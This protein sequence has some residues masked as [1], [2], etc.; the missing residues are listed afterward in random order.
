[1]NI[2]ELMI[3]NYVKCVGC[4]DNI[5]QVISLFD[6]DLVTIQNSDDT[7]DCMLDRVKPIPITIEWLMKNGFEKRYKDILDYYYYTKEIKDCFISITIRAIS[8][9]HSI[10][11]IYNNYLSS[12]SYADIQYIHQLQNLLNILYIKE[13]FIV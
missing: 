12:Y 1:M 13:E 9:E 3:G 7:F 4:K 8:K 6:G 11:Y 10:C 5:Y 2:N